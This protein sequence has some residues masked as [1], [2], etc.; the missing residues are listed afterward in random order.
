MGNTG[1]SIWDVSPSRPLGEYLLEDGRRRSSQYWNNGVLV[2]RSHPEVDHRTNRPTT[3]SVSVQT[4]NGSTA[5][6]R[7][8]VENRQARTESTHARRNTSSSGRSTRTSG[9]TSTGRHSNT[10]QASSN[11]SSNTSPRESSSR[12]SNSSALRNTFLGGQSVQQLIE[13]KM[14]APLE[15]GKDESKD[16]SKEDCPICFGFYTFLNYTACCNKPICTHCFV[17]MHKLR[18]RGTTSVCP[19]CNAEPMEIVFYGESNPE[20]WMKGTL[21]DSV[22]RQVNQLMVEISLIRR[23]WVEHPEI[24]D[25]LK[26]SGKELYAN[27]ENI[28]SVLPKQ[29]CL[30]GGRTASLSDLYTD[31]ENFISNLFREDLTENDLAYLEAVFRSLHDVCFRILADIAVY[32]EQ[33]TFCSTLSSFALESVVDAKQVEHRGHVYSHLSNNQQV[34]NEICCEDNLIMFSDEGG[35]EEERS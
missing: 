30:S 26:N 19:F 25:L 11:R 24:A 27:T 4:R 29:I 3:R 28:F 7:P 20:R 12:I 6:S 13:K 35:S 8:S 21:R 17:T 33:R 10:S 22:E 15:S 32:A 2:P 23:S 31:T 9:R 14:L 5:S 34:S 16:S 18:R 1:S